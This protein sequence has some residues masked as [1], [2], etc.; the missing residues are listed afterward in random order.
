MPN[1]VFERQKREY[2][3]QLAQLQEQKTELA[4]E[5]VALRAKID[6]AYSVISSNEMIRDQLEKDLKCKNKNGIKP[7]LKPHSAKYSQ[8]NS[9]SSSSS[10]TNSESKTTLSILA[11]Y[12]KLI[13]L[14][15]EIILSKKNKVLFLEQRYLLLALYNEDL[16]N[17][18]NILKSTTVFSAK[19]YRVFDSSINLKIKTNNSARPFR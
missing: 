2:E 16:I 9:S 7:N 1:E 10:S 13:D 15:N 5:I 12:A 14:E 18:I 19:K 11:R 3:D 4:K 6:E 17:E 8:S